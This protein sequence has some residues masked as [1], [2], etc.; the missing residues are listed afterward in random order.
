MTGNVFC[1]PADLDR[2][3]KIIAESGTLL[4]PASD[5]AGFINGVDLAVDGGMSEALWCRTPPRHDQAFARR[6]TPN[7][8]GSLGVPTIR[9]L[10][11]A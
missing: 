6:V 8:R 1:Q 4:F 11:P 7:M 9:P 3:Q 5:E 10:L 2:L